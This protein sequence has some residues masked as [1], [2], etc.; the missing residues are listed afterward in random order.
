MK[1]LINVTE[2]NTIPDN[3][4]DTKSWPCEGVYL[5]K[6]EPALYYVNKWSV[7][8]W[9]YA[10]DHLQEYVVPEQQV[11]ESLFL[12]AIAATHGKNL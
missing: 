4:T 1:Y 6:D 9:S 8:Y 2:L 10:A 3:W 7:N 5:I 12:K 11:P